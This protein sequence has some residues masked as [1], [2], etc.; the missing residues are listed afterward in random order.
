MRPR[1]TPRQKVLKG[2][3]ISFGWATLE[4][5]VRNLSETGAAIQVAQAATVPDQFSLTVQAG[6]PSR[7]CQVMWRKDDR[8]GVSFK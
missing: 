8:L 6:G 1:S 4:C 3:T 5:I 2:G 7:L